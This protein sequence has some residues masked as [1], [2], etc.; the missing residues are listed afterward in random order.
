[1][2]A[3]ET[4]RQY[5]LGKTISQVDNL[6]NYSLLRRVFKPTLFSECIRVQKTF[7]KSIMV[8]WLTLLKT[9]ANSLD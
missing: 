2:T 5:F 9:F 4:N 3:D 8:P 1:M 7:T 6:L